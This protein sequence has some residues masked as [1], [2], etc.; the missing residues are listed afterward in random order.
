MESNEEINANRKLSQEKGGN[1]KM[2]EIVDNIS[3]SQTSESCMHFISC[4]ANF[5]QFLIP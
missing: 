5:S 1:T 3:A 4:F 2:E